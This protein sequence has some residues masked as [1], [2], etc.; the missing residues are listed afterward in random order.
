MAEIR[1]RM[2]TSTS[3]RPPGLL[4]GCARCCRRI[5]MRARRQVP[6][7]SSCTASVCRRASSAVLGSIGSSPATCREAHPSFAELPHSCASPRTSSSAATARSCN[8]CHS[9][10]RLARGRSNYPGPQRLQRFLG[11]DRARGHRRGALQEAQY[12]SLGALI[13]R[14]CALSVDSTRAHRGPQRCRAGRK[15]DPGGAFDWPHLRGLGALNR[16]APWRRSWRQRTSVPRSCRAST[17]A[18][19]NR[20]SDSRFRYCGDLRLTVRPRRVTTR[21][22]R[23]AGDRA[24]QV[25]GAGCR[26]AAWKDEI[27]QRRQSIVQAIEG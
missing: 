8:T 18:S 3:M 15:N 12:G 16:A 19:T 5:S 4:L 27:L 1:M 17:R 21:A 9:G 6:T 2:R 10:A 14:C 13:R 24:R 20:R 11:R 22:A 23:R 26:A 7:S 25:A